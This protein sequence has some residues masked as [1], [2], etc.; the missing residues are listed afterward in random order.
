MT[1]ILINAILALIVAG[2]IFYFVRRIVDLIPMDGIIKQ[3]VDLLIL[4]VVVLIILFYVALPLIHALL[5]LS[6]SIH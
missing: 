4:L 1:G 6:I 5:G 3:V 2:V